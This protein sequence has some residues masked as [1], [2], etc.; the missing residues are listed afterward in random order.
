MRSWTLPLLLLGACDDPSIG[1][2]VGPGPGD[3]EDD[4]CGA[5]VRSTVAFDEVA[6]DGQSGEVAMDLL[7]G[8]HVFE[9]AWFDGRDA[10]VTVSFDTLASEVAAIDFPDGDPACARRLVFDATLTVTASDGAFDVTAPLQITWSHPWRFHDQ[11]FA[12]A[13]TALDDTDAA[14]LAPEATSLVG[15]LRLAEPDSVDPSTG[16]LELLTATPDEPSGEEDRRARLV[17]W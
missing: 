13:L 16:Y 2:G 17:D 9:G 4:L 7:R 10:D 8:P 11:G 3:V 5:E 14:A 6:F 15:W 1:E 12:A